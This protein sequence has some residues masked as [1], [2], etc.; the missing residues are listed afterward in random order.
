MNQCMLRR[1]IARMGGGTLLIVLGLA[2]TGCQAHGGGQ[3]APGIDGTGVAQGAATFSLTFRCEMRRDQ[4]VV[5]GQLNYQDQGSRTG[6]G[7]GPSA[8]QVHGE[9][10]PL[11]FLDAQTCE[12]V[13]QL[14]PGV[15]LFEGRY[16]P[17]GRD[18]PGRAA[19]DGTFTVLVFDQGE[20]GRATED[21]TGDYFAIELFGGEYSGYTRGDYIENGNLQVK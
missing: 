20:G 18:W 2:L 6:N 4:A 17:Q 11:T 5:T 21:I 10:E 16:Q 13:R 14:L 15:A 9:I 12:D 1:R 7:S 3:L 8:V 19:Q